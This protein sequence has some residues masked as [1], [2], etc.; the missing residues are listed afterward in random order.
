M[1][2]RRAG[3]SMQRVRKVAAQL[4]RRHLSLASVRLYWDGR[5]VVVMDEEGDLESA[6]AHP[7]QGVFPLDGIALAA[8]HERYSSIARPV[9]IKELRTRTTAL[10]AAQKKRTAAIEN[11]R[12][13][14]PSDGV[15]EADG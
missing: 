14:Q 15:A 7:G 4:R 9:D 3:V 12:S 2:L 5:D 11:L 6:I 10:R 8:W 1:E 13:V